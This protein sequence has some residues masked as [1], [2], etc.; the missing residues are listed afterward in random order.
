MVNFSENGELGAAAGSEPPETAES[1]AA[2]IEECQQYRDRLVNDTV[3][4][5][6]RAK[7]P[8]S[9]VMQQLEPELAKLDG[10][11][12]ELKQRKADLEVG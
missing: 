7:L 8:K 12:A 9:A 1:L 11:L 4:A 5:A 10:A 3:A 6:K 2:L